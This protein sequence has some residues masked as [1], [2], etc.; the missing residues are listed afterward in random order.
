MLR[1]KKRITL[2]VMVADLTK[3]FP[4]RFGEAPGEESNNAEGAQARFGISIENITPQRRSQLNLKA[5]GGVLVDDV[6]PG[7]FADDIGILPHDIIVAINRKPVSS[8][9]DVKRIQGE[10]QAGQAVAFQVMRQDPRTGQ[11]QTTFLPGTMPP[12]PK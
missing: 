11:W 7:S 2:P 8:V 5:Q 3:V 9:Q 10:F 12:Q 4:G 6:T 1:D